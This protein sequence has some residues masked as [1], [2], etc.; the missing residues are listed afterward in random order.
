MPIA[1]AVALWL[2]LLSR[3]SVADWSQ[4][5][6]LLCPVAHVVSG[7]S[8]PPPLLFLYSILKQRVAYYIMAL[9]N[10]QRYYMQR[11]CRPMLSRGVCPSV[12]FIY[13]VKTNNGG[14]NCCWGMAKTCDYRRISGFSACRPVLLLSVVDS[15]PPGQHAY[16]LRN[17]RSSFSSTHSLILAGGVI[18]TAAEYI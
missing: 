11:F 1:L 16:K 10:L 12:T 14:V 4:L 9:N 3:V 8:P 2:L 18:A 13:S 15:P 5:L 17:I 7:Q 6:P